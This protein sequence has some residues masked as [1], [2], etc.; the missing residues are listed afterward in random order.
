MEKK[1]EREKIAR[2][3]MQLIIHNKRI[4]SSKVVDTCYQLR[5]ESNSRTLGTFTACP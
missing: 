3:N 4:K 2:Q 5:D 1:F